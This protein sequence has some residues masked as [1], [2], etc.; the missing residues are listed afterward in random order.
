MPTSLI[1]YHPLQFTSLHHYQS[2]HHHQAFFFNQL[3]PSSAT[4]FIGNRNQ[5]PIATSNQFF[6]SI[7]NDFTQ[8][9]TTITFTNLKSSI[10]TYPCPIFCH[11]HPKHKVLL[12]YN[13]CPIFLSIIVLPYNF[14]FF[15]KTQKNLKEQKQKKRKTYQFF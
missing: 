3:P 1:R 7:H 13:V 10:F 6:W 15:Q 8:T 5:P 2:I 11:R 4:L 12:I 9:T 14:L